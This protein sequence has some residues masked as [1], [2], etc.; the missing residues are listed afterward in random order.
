[1]IHCQLV[2]RPQFFKI[3]SIFSLADYSQWSCNIAK[4]LS[5]WPI[6]K[7]H[8]KALQTLL[9]QPTRVF[10]LLCRRHSQHGDWSETSPGYLFIGSTV[11]LRAA[12]EHRPYEET[13]GILGALCSLR[14]PS[15]HSPC[16]LQAFM[17]C[18]SSAPFADPARH[19]TSRAKGTL[20]GGKQF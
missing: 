20:R 8:H 11:M 17:P 18:L 1:M 19:F 2:F 16:I 7:S 13:N 4:V 3:C 5:Y 9:F 14:G 12:S 10:P 6:S 15:P